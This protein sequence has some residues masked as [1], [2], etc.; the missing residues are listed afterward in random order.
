MSS[1]INLRAFWGILFCHLANL[2]AQRFMNLRPLTAASTLVP[3][4]LALELRRISG[5]SSSSEKP[6]DDNSQDDNESHAANDT[7]YNRADG[8]LV[9]AAGSGPVDG[10]IGEHDCDFGIVEDGIVSAVW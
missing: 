7:A 3:G 5:P 10:A 4:E 9:G 2:P 1:N 8:S 6:E